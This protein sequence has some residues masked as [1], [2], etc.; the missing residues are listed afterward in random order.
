[1][2][3]IVACGVPRTG[4]TLVWQILCR[5]LPHCRVVKAHPGSWAPEP[6]NF[7]VGS[8]RNP[9]DN[10]ASCFRSRVIGDDG[11]GIHVEGT[12]KGLKAE[13]NMLAN[14]YKVMGEM[15][16]KYKGKI[17]ILR[18][19][20][21]FENYSL[22]YRTIEV[23][24]DIKIPQIVQLEISNRF[25]VIE[26][27]KRANKLEDFNQ[28]DEDKIHGDHIGNIYPGYWADYIPEKY[29]ED[30]DH[31]CTPIAKEWDYENQ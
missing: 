16:E 28:V 24:F 20:E 21:F 5:A 27:K 22:I 7:I 13:M 11:D 17:A 23:Y 6:C 14:N 4:S 9:Y 1:M 3:K 29:K 12:M 25:S 18:Y 8:I 30:F 19:E 26:N 15:I 31:I 2:N 10:I